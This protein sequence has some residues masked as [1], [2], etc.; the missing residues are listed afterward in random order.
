MPRM[1]TATHTV[2][3]LLRT[4][5]QALAD[6]ANARLDM[7]LLLAHVLGTDRTALYARADHVLDPGQVETFM[8]LLARRTQGEP[9]AYLTGRREFWSLPLAVTPQ[10]LIPR[11]ETE[12]L[13][14]WALALLVDRADARIADLGTGSGAIAIA[15]ASEL[16]H[17]NII[18]TDL[19]ME[20][21]A[22]ARANA[23]HLCPGRIEFRQGNWCDA[24]ADLEFDLI[25]SNP[26]Y[27]AAGDPALQGDGLPYEP[28]SA[29]SAGTD[30]L[31]AMRLIIPAARIH[32]PPGGMLLLEHGADQSERLAELLALHD[33]GG[34]ESRSDL[35]GL[36][37]AMLAIASPPAD[38][39]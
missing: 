16:P 14:E 30:G 24:L 26:P 12:L 15:L 18:A 9:L 23:D 8:A 6:G 33:Y 29:L 31:D 13:V 1:D 21:L 7:E 10:T 34:I 4:A 22:V 11:P 25:V 2:G 38:S 37:R 39:R 5:R 27:V 28:T 35:S 17:A 19:S 32:L 36:P 3:G 20:T